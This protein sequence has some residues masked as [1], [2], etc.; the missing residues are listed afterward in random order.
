M[1]KTTP[2]RRTRGHASI[3]TAATPEVRAVRAAQL[4]ERDRMMQIA[5]AEDEVKR[6]TEAFEKAKSLSAERAALD[7]AMARLAEL[8]G[9]TT[10]ESQKKKA[11]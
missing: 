1:L 6:A 5:A 4:A 7:A 8:K 10:D 9:E 2:T 11:A 3:A